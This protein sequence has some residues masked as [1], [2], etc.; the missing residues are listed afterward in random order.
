M[1]SAIEEATDILNEVIF[2]AK[3]A[4]D[5]L[6]YYEIHD[7][8][9]ILKDNEAA[10]IYRSQLSRISSLTKAASDIITEMEEMR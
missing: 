5:T 1:T 9:S 3:R 10:R 8:E 7:G 6:E 2:T 4:R